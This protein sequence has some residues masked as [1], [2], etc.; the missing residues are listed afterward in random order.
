MSDKLI[1]TLRYRDDHEQ[2]PRPRRGR[3]FKGLG[4]LRGY[5]V[6]AIAGPRAQTYTTHGYRRRAGAG[7][8]AGWVGIGA[9]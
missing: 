5:G 2:G 1:A 8:E 3:S 9:R 4:R 7:L 6:S